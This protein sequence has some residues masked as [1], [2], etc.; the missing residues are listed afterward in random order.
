MAEFS[1]YCWCH[2]RNSDIDLQP[3]AGADE[4]G[5]DAKASGQISHMVKES[6]AIGVCCERFGCCLLTL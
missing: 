5:G 4:V 1:H 6:H 3:L 2:D